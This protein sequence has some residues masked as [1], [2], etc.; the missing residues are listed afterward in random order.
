M[1]INVLPDPIDFLR[2]IGRI[3]RTDHFCARVC[4]F[5][6]ATCRHRLVG[7]PVKNS[8]FAALF[9]MRAAVLTRIVLESGAVPFPGLKLKQL[10]GRGGFAEVWEARNE[11]NE[12]IALKFISSEKTASTVKEMKSLQSLQQL[13]HPNLL[14]TER[15]WSA[16][17]YIV[18]AMELADASLFD[19]LDAYHT[20]YQTP[21]PPEILHP[22]MIQAAAGLDFMNA[23]QHLFEGRKVGFQH[24][25]VKPS[26]MLVVGDRIK[27]A[28]FGLS[29][30]TIAMN[31]PYPKCG[32]LDFAAP[33]IH[34]GILSVR[35]DQFS[36]AVSYY[37]LRTGSF[38]FPPPPDGFR[39]R[40][41]YARPAPD[42]GQVAKSERRILERALEVQPERRWENCEIF[43]RELNYAW[44][45]ASGS[46]PS[47][48][49]VVVG[50]A[51]AQA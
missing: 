29:S 39:R 22:Y 34:R 21:I 30:T 10:R 46:S 7:L 16:P 26:N 4:Q 2:G 44:T 32:T 50:A 31:N 45:E 17:G 48:S 3:A 37:Y 23:R 42:L 13:H 20:E 11:K 28:D 35:S 14:R 18:I 41:S 47:S 12:P 9:L 36:L 6:P 19:L 27:L 33:E 15:V 25:D 38:P 40:Y 1:R 8:P 24:C 5:R 51:A 49:V 43:I